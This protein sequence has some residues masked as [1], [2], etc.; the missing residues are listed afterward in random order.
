MAAGIR[1]LPAVSV[2]NAATHS[3]EAT[4]AAEP[5]LLPPVMIETEFDETEFDE[6]E[7]V[8]AECEVVVVAV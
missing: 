1:T 8:E 2:P 3:P 5:A 7:F 4:A 6:P